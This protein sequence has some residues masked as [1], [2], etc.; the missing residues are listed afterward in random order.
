MPNRTIYIGKQDEALLKSAQQISRGTI[1][2]TIVAA[3]K[4]YVSHHQ[5]QKAASPQVADLQEIKLQVGPRGF[6][7][8]EKFKGKLLGSWKG[9]SDNKKFWF[10]TQI[11]IS[12]ES[13]LI[14]YHSR[15]LPSEILTNPAKWHDY[16][17]A[18]NGSEL[19]EFADMG[20]LEVKL[21]G[22]L[23]QLAGSIWN[24]QNT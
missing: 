13:K 8:E 23:A 24:T 21:P 22:A 5:G 17:N 12:A 4:E 16:L 9:F 3:L 6:Q 18:D 14:I 20:E 1:S 15:V 2:G 11:F 7:K 19:L 10:E